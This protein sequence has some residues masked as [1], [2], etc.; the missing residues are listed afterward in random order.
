MSS[1][2]LYA[3]LIF[4]QHFFTDFFAARLR[5][6]LDPRGAPSSTNEL[7]ALSM[8]SRTGLRA[9][10]VKRDRGSIV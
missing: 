1:Q 8:R 3:S 5:E 4:V 10:S 7:I 2:Y 9:R 6:T